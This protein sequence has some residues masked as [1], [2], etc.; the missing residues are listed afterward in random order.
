MDVYG[1]GLYVGELARIRIRIHWILLAFWAVNLKD[2]LQGNPE[3]RSMRLLLWGLGVLLTFGSILLHEFGHCFAARTV[4]GD[5]NEIL[6]WPFGGLAF[7]HCPDTWRANLI[8]AVGGPLVTLAI[9]AVSW[10]TFHFIDEQ[11]PELS[12]TNPYFVEAYYYLV[13]W[14]LYIL[15][16]NL[17]PLYPMDGGRIFHAL[18]WAWFER[19]GGPGWS[20]YGRASRLTLQVTRVTAALGI[21]Y[22]IQEQEIPMAFIFVWAWLQAERLKGSSTYL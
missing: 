22:A 8:T 12:I 20:G 19:P 7:C 13:H 3:Q 6:L 2:A 15:I 9:F 16:F 5:A 10:P 18:A 21:V 14:N 11:R 17:I 1:W 4:G